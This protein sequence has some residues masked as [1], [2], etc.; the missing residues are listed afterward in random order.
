MIH[1]TETSNQNWTKC[2]VFLGEWVISESSGFCPP[3][4]PKTYRSMSMSGRCA[5]KSEYESRPT[6]RWWWFLG[7]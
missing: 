5:R 7:W 4:N 6:D 2:K 3:F 1:I